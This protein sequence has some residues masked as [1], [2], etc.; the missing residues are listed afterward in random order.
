MEKKISK[1]TTL[2]LEMN[3]REVIDFLEGHKIQMEVFPSELGLISTGLDEV[4]KI[5]I[6]ILVDL[7]ASMELSFL[8]AYLD[9]KKESLIREENENK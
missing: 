8:K 7:K 9:N 1:T 4:D 5:K 3:Y 6:N 2:N